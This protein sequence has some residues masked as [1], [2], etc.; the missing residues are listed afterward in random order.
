MGIIEEE[1]KK[2]FESWQKMS[3]DAVRRTLCIPDEFVIGHR[4][5]VIPPTLLRPALR[6]L[7]EKV[8]DRFVV[9][10]CED[11]EWWDAGKG[12]TERVWHDAELRS[13]LS[14]WENYYH[15]QDEGKVNV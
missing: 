8:I 5:L 14:F 2:W 10:D 4:I 11:V 15:I 13:R 3:E 9:N 7:E 1:D 12:H 6:L